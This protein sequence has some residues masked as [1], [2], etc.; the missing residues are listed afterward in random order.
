MGGRVALGIP[1]N[2]CGFQDGPEDL[3]A[4][5]EISESMK[6]TARL[7]KYKVEQDLFNFVDNITTESNKL[8][9]H[10]L[11]IFKRIQHIVSTLFQ[12]Y[13]KH[14]KKKLK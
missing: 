11:I 2:N 8:N 6:L 3:V 12:G 14:Q 5:S 7:F 1:Q 10:R 4:S 9:P 13:K